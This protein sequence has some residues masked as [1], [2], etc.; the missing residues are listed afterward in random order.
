VIKVWC[1]DDVKRNGDVVLSETSFNNVVECG[2]SEGSYSVVLVLLLLFLL[3][4]MMK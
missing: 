2:R 4:W 3:W 1:F